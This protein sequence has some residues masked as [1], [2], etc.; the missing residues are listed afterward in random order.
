MRNVLPLGVQVVDDHVRVALVTS[1]E[2]NHLIDSA[3]L[4][5]A[6]HRIGPNVDACRDG[7]A[8]GEHDIEGDVVG[9]IN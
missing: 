3:E 9:E 2:H 6:L 5:Q 1:R 7:R 4:L 8:V